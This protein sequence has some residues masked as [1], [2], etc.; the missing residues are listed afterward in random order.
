MDGIFFTKTVE[1]LWKRT[2]STPRITQNQRG[3]YKLLAFGT[4]KYSIITKRYGNSLEGYGFQIIRRLKGRFTKSFKEAVDGD[5]QWM[6]LWEKW[7]A[8][9]R[10]WSLVE[11]EVWKNTY[12]VGLKIPK[13]CLIRKIFARTRTGEISKERSVSSIPLRFNYLVMNSSPGSASSS[14]SLLAV[15]R[16]TNAMPTVP[17]TKKATRIAHNI[18]F[19]PYLIIPIIPISAFF[20]GSWWNSLN[21]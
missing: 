15:S 21:R 14:N 20:Q 13:I 16:Q 2:G 3:F 1:K 19:P 8:E 9:R 10:N 12:R 6:G 17:P 5:R 7:F 11:N 18:V 4:L